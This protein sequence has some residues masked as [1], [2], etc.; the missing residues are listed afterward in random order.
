[1]QQSLSPGTSI[2]ATQYPTLID[3][4]CPV[5]R[6]RKAFAGSSAWLDDRGLDTG[7]G[8][9]AGGD[10]EQP[11]YRRSLN[12]VHDGSGVDTGT[13]FSSYDRRSL[14]QELGTKGVPGR[15]D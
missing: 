4:S 6:P 3:C 11:E 7:V 8:E 13:D 15:P 9:V 12:K 10:R 1:M 2:E 5:R 14:G